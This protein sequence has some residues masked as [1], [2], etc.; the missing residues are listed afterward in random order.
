[1]AVVQVASGVFLFVVQMPIF[2][3]DLTEDVSEEVKR[4]GIM[5]EIQEESTGILNL[6]SS[7]ALNMWN[8]TGNI[9]SLA[10]VGL[11]LAITATVSLRVIK[12]VNLIGA[13]RYYWFLMWILPTEILL[14]VSLFDYHRVTVVWVRHW[15]NTQS[16]DYIRYQFCAN[17]TANLECR[18]PELGGEFYE[19]VTEL[20]ESQYNST[21]CENIIENAQDQMITYSTI[22][23]TANAIWGLVLVA[24]VFLALVVLERI[25]SS[26]IVQSSTERNIP[27]WLAL[28][29][30]GSCIMGYILKNETSTLSQADSGVGWV[31]TM[32]YITSGMFFGA[33]ILG[34]FT[35]TSVY[36]QRD[37][38]R[39]KA[40]VNLFILMIIITIFLVGAIF[41][42]SLVYSVGLVDNDLGGMRGTIA[43]RVDTANSCTSCST[44]DDNLDEEIQCVEWSKQDVTKILQTQLKQS[45]TVAAIFLLYAFS[46]LRFGFVLRTHVSMYQIDYL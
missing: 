9:F 15:W 33:A 8:L 32:F 3:E 6:S 22:F 23:F 45:A 31:G 16:F 36:N 14:V 39:K 35:A 12:V 37:K 17:G 18:V 5:V 2:F 42:N 38:Q 41:A 7:F 34:C 10:F 43:C 40:A 1:M 46:A 13:L 27:A 11:I 44:D 24:M 30:V 29:I 28:P 21:D 25:I 4:D 19:N 20:C 26:P